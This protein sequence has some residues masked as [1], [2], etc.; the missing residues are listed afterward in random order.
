MFMPPINL[1]PQLECPNCNQLTPKRKPAC[2][3]CERTIPENY[4]KTQKA[5]GHERRRR[6]KIAAIVLV[7]V[8]LIALTWIF[9][10]ISG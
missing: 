8:F 7:P 3:H 9:H 6:A 2:V 10:R 1:T 4:R 5:A